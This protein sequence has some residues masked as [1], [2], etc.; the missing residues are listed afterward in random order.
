MRGA[1]RTTFVRGRR[2]FERG[3]VDTFPGAPSGVLLGAP[4]GARTV[5]RARA[6]G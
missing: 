2:V 3:A 6:S 5:D 4:G 1:V